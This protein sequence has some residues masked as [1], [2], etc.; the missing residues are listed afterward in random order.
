MFTIAC[1][2]QNYWRIPPLRFTH[3]AG[4]FL[5]ANLISSLPAG[6]YGSAIFYN[7]FRQPWYAPPDWCFAPVWLLLNLTSLWAL[8]HALNTPVSSPAKSLLLR[9]ELLGWVLF[10]IFS[11]LFF[12]L[13][14]PILGAVDTALGWV[15]ASC[16]V[17]WAQRLSRLS[18]GLIALRW[19]WLTLATA[20]SG[21]I[22]INNPR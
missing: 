12:G 19:I 17:V 13:Q 8:A 22:A 1:V 21:Y 15:V 16:S 20:V 4:I 14:S 11:P 5:V 6:I 2:I 9:S 7:E 3:A 10:A 18:A